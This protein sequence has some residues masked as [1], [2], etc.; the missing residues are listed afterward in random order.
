MMFKNRPSLWGIALLFLLALHHAAAYAQ[1]PVK[2]TVKDSD[3]NT[4]PGVSVTLKGTNVKTSTN[5][6]GVFQLDVPN[7]EATLVFS[8]VGFR[9][10]E[11]QV[12]GRQ[13]IEITL[14]PDQTSLDEVVVVG[15]G[16]QRRTDV[17]GAVASFSA[18][19]LQIQ[20]MPQTT[21][22]QSLQGRIPG[23][24]ITTTSSN[25]EGNSNNIQVRGRNSITAGNAPLI[26]LDGI[27]YSDQLSE[28]NPNDI[29]SIEVLKD[30]SSAAIYGSRGAN[31]VI[32]VTTKKGNT[33]KATIAYN[34]FYG[35]DEIAHLPDMMDATTFYETK[36][37]RY[38][39]GSLTRTEIESHE[40]GINTDW[41]DLATQVGQRQ[42]HNISVSGGSEETRYFISGAFNNT[43][44]IA[45]NDEFKR[46]NLRVNLDTKIRPWLTIG[47]NTQ[48]GMTTRDKMSASFSGAFD[49]NPMA[50]PYEDDGVT[51]RIFPW[52]EDA[53]FSNPLQG[54]DVLQEDATR[55]II[56]NN[57]LQVDIPY[58]PGLSYKLNTGYTYRYRAVETYYGRNTR[59]GLQQGGVSEIDNWANEDW[60]IE[61][62]VNYDRTFGDHHLSLTGLYSAQQRVNKNH[63]LDANGFPSDIMTNYQ[64]ILATVWLPSDQYNEMKYI[65]QMA[66][67][68]YSYL[69]KYL[70]TLTAR[71]DGYSAFGDLTK[72]GIFP[73]VAVGWN[74][75][76]ENFISDVAWIN[77]LKLRLS[78]G[79]NGNQ[80]INPYSTLPNLATQPYL[81]TDKQTAIGFYPNSLGDPSLGWETTNQAN[82]GLDFA[83]LNN[84]LTGT[85]DYY[86]ANTHDLL[87]SKLI[88]PVNGVRSITQNIGQTRNTGIDFVISGTPI[89]NDN[90]SWTTDFNLTH[91]RNKIVDVGL[92]DANGNPVDDLGNRWFIGQPIS[93]NFSYIF[94]G[95]WQQGDDITNSAQPDAR[96]GDV[97]VR[98]VNQDGTISPDDRQIIGSTVPSFAA[99]WNNTFKY[100]NFTLSLMLRTVQG[101][102]KFNEM[103]NT[104]FDGRTRTLNRNFWTPENPH[105]EFP[106][107]RDDNN[108]FG[109]IYFG[110]QNDASFIRLN[111]VAFAYRFPSSF[112]ERAKM[113]NLELFVN[114]KNLA[115]VTSWVGLDP[116]LN[117]QRAIPLT[118]TYLLGL[119][120]GF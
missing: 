77:A 108:P 112:L 45:I 35:I 72:F 60:L 57:F 62:I 119:R 28:I 43:K 63:D 67:L 48:F 25:A 71:R 88:S 68:N 1:I 30:A 2:G 51:R 13:Q 33:G 94:D 39:E 42:Q 8:Y 17:T 82:F 16:T 3:G 64:N 84:R 65:S 75:D 87:L 91:Y 49:M 12:A 40:Q 92:Y 15:Y 101:V 18:E 5:T 19:R 105:N 102:T 32:L 6:E 24:S 54:L 29:A 79:K 80:A 81:T 55:S 107:N 89:S 76:Q 47:T 36:V 113:S 59:N 109:V 53:F 78:Y 83:I 26:V 111:E 27:P 50:L 31:G 23:L 7:A 61:N 98:D 11:T 93:V 21:I 56:S 115:T 116:E 37:G 46:T 20:E 38:G 52:V 73:S 74:I 10:Y 97:R 90:F 114:A 103:M 106:A 9:T 58:V 70:L 69:G 85:V 44:G 86:I 4:L 120:F 96:P 95:I 41:V 99:G 110:K 22:T 117:D 104:F 66:R 118:R 34:G 14:S 100:K